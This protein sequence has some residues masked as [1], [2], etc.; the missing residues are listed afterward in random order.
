MAAAALR[1]S[2]VAAA[3][4]AGRL[5]RC[6]SSSCCRR[7]EFEFDAH[8]L[9]AHVDGLGI[10]MVDGSGERRWDPPT[11]EEEGESNSNTNINGSNGSRNRPG[12]NSVIQSTNFDDWRCTSDR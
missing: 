2:A 8:P 3:A 11:G 9:L 10:R 5:A 6:A 1:Q 7:F 4:V 12:Q